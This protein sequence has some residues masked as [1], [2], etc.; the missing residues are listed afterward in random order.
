MSSVRGVLK[1]G[2]GVLKTGMNH[3]EECQM[4]E[5]KS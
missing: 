2:K 3:G 5:L 1:T 4:S